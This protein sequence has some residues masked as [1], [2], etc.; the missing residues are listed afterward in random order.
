MGWNTCVVVLNDALDQIEK[1][2]EFGK[3]LAAAIRKRSITGKEAVDV[4]AGNHCNA[5]LVVHQSHADCNF[6]VKVGGNYG[7]VVNSSAFVE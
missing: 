3:K 6:Y 2:P 5:A 7:E 4:S 1:D